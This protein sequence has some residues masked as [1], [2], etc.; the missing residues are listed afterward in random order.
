MGLASSAWIT[1]VAALAISAAMASSG[2]LFRTALILLRVFPPTHR[3]QVAA[4][5]LGRWLTPLV[6]TIFGRVA[7]TPR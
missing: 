5:F 4:L 2:L 7:T 3:G 1:A 6:P